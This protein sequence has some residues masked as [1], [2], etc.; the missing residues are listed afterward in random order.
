MRKF[1]LVAA[2]VL[3]SATA[4][5]EGKRGLGLASND[6]P[7]VT[8][9]AKPADTPAETPKYT[10]RPTAVDTTTQ[11]ADAVKPADTPKRTA[12]S[13][14]PRRWYVGYG[15]TTARRIAS[16]LQQ[17]YGTELQRYG[18]ELQQRYAAYR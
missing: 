9:P 5:A 17:R 16:T 2:M 15:A 13:D 14:R 10:A 4:Q 3:V 12:R 6:D 7:V 8:T 1:I 18:S 11:P